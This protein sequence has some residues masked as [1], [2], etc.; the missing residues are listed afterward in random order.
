MKVQGDPKIPPE[1]N[2]FKTR[3][4]TIDCAA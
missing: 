3:R 4:V 2:K 1:K